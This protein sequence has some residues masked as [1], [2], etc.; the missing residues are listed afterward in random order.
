VG[1]EADPAATSQSRGGD[2]SEA[3]A[4]S[5]GR[6][7]LRP[8]WSCSKMMFPSPQ[9]HPSSK[10]RTPNQAPESSAVSGAFSVDE[11]ARIFNT[12]VVSTR[13]QESKD[14]SGE[15]YALMET[16]A[17]GA[18]LSAARQLATRQGISELQAAE[19]LIQTFRKLDQIWDGYVFQEG[20]TRL[21]GQNLTV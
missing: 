11:M 8:L 21:R 7:W 5:E 12:A 16:P 9:T 2:G 18:I 3:N 20:V 13:T 19:Q 15:L 10:N 17:F 1:Y 4:P 6:P 14:I